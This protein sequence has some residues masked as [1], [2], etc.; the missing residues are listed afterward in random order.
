MEFGKIKATAKWWTGSKTELL[1][2]KMGPTRLTSRR[3]WRSCSTTRSPRTWPRAMGSGAT[4][5]PAF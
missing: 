5:W 1:N 3:L 2:N 4:I